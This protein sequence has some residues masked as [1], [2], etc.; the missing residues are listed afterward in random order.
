MSAEIEAPLIGV[1]RHRLAVDGKGV[2]S[3]VAFHGCTLRCRF[4]L[5]PHCLVPQR[6]SR[7]VTPRALVDELMIDNLYFLATGGGVAFGGGEPC[8]RSEFIEKFRA[9]APPRWRITIET[10]L[11]VDSR[12]LERLLPIVNE[13]IVDI[14]DLD[15]GVYRNYTGG[16]VARATDN[17]RWLLSHDGMAARVIVRVPHIPDYNTPDGVART[18]A[19]LYAM[20]VVNIDEF[21]YRLPQ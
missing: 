6:V 16:D 4:C 10:S 14:K 18:I 17:L 2:T 21:H 19:T 5:N 8:L 20:G 1:S 13:Y 15:A 7:R 12:H 3:L 11:N 9:L